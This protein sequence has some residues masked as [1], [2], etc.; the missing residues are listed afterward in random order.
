MKP[1]KK[2]EI[3][4]LLK[5]KIIRNSCRGMVDEEN[6][7]IGYYSSKNRIYIEDKYVDIAKK[8]LK[9]L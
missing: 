1:I 8:L 2:K 5:K 3:D 6:I 4:L 9:D 7:P